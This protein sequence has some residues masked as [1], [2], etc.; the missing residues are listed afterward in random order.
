MVEVCR[1]MRRN[2]PDVF[3]VS[4]TT[5]LPAP[6]RVVIEALTPCITEDR[7]QRIREVLSRRTLR[8]VPVLE[9][10]TDPHNV[11]A[12]F[13]SADAFGT[14]EV[15]V[16]EG[17]HGLLASHSVS[18]G[19]H[20]WLDVRVH[21]DAEACVAHLASRGYRV[22][23]AE[24]G[25]VSRPEDLRSG[26]RTAVVFGNEHRGASARMRSLAHGS[27]SIP[28]VGFV[29]S[30]NVSVAA[31]ITLYTATAGREGDLTAEDF[32]EKLA[33]TLLR[34]VRDAEGIVRE[35]WPEPGT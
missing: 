5:A 1:R 12:V 14:A 21:A 28:M 18:R 22:L 23:V 31:A 20:R 34:L 25:G 27:Y 2:G 11:S 3:P 32:E 33:R 29:E 7:L 6:P 9:E 35:R 10:I 24:M 16:I 19:T 4:P 26:P 8:V 13:R 17:K 30:L 15:H